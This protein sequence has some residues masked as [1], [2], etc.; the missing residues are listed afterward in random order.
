[1]RSFVFAS[2]ACRQPGG[3]FSP[4]FRELWFSKAVTLPEAFCYT[5]EASSAIYSIPP[6][7]SLTREGT[8]SSALD[9]QK[10]FSASRSIQ[11][12]ETT[13]GDMG[14]NMNTGSGASYASAIDRSFWVCVPEN[15]RKSPVIEVRIADGTDLRERVASE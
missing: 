3:T 15:G 14:Q 1:M 4:A 6:H 5:I 10:V 11:F 7:F 13:P 9:I 8:V 12:P 2:R